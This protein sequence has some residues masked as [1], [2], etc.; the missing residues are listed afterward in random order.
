MTHPLTPPGITAGQGLTHLLTRL[1]RLPT[2]ARPPLLRRGA[3]VGDGQ[4]RATLSLNLATATARAP[5]RRRITTSSRS[6]RQ[7][8]AM[9]R[10][11][12][13][14]RR[15]RRVLLPPQETPGRREDG[16]TLARAL[17]RA[18]LASVDILERR[19]SYG[20]PDRPA[21]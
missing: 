3:C 2:H 21:R 6:T 11:N 15:T 9:P 10:R 19:D 8:T 7:E 12:T 13:P 16:E 20:L 1:T 18:G 5:A 17:V 14:T 4:W